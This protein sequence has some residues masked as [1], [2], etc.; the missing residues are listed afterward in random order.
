MKKQRNVT[1][2]RESKRNKWQ[3]QEGEG[4]EKRKLNEAKGIVR[5]NE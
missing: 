2:G 5:E 1:E 3:K 4:K